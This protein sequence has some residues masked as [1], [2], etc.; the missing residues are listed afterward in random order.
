MPEAPIGWSGV[1]NPIEPARRTRSA[2][3]V[4]PHFLFN[5]LNIVAVLINAGRPTDANRALLAL[6][7]ILRYDYEM[8]DQMAPL[9][10]ELLVIESY[11]TIQRFRFGE[12]LAL[13]IV[14]PT[15]LT[16]VPIVPGCVLDRVENAFEAIEIRVGP[17]RVV[18]SATALNGY[19]VVEVNAD[20]A[21]AIDRL[22]MPLN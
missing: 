17:G 22:T 4:R 16:R 8:S 5:A 19:L 3:R 7:S 12:R 9:Q 21:Q 13:E 15:E 1:G 20:G 18:L 10:N 11:A 6:A 2:G 14:I